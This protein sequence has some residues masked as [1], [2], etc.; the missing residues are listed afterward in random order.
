M[1]VSESGPVTQKVNPQIVDSIN[2]EELNFEVQGGVRWDDG[3]EA[4]CTVCL[5]M[6]Q[7]CLYSQCEVTYEVRRHCK[8]SSLTDGE[9]GN[10]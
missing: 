3:W 5:Q 1:H 9:L 6:F 7:Y 4:T 10:T 8:D 2:L